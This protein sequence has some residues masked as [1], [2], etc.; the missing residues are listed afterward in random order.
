M[1]IIYD[2]NVDEHVDEYL[3]I[4]LFFGIGWGTFGYVLAS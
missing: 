4:F 3:N 2:E 1:I